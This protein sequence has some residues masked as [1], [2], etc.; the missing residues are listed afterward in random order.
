VF[1]SVPLRRRIVAL[2]TAVALSAVALTGCS[3]ASPQA[4]SALNVIEPAG[5]GSLDP[6]LING[7]LAWYVD[8]AYSPLIQTA[9]GGALT[10]GLATHWKYVGAGNTEFELTLRDGVTFSDGTKLTAKGV[11]AHLDY[12]K[13]A[14][15]P[16]SGILATMTSVTTTGN[17]VDI[18]FS[19][20]NPDLPAYFASTGL[21]TIIS[22]DGLAHPKNLGTETAGAGPYM[23]DSSATVADDHYVY[24]PNPHYWDKANVH[25]KKVT[26]KVIPN[27]TSVLNAL[28]SGQAD[29]AP[30]DF[31]TATAA[32][33]A[34]LTVNFVP[35]VFSGLNL[36]DR[37]GTLVPALGDVRVRQAINYAIDRDAI[38]KALYGKYGTATTQTT[39]DVGFQKD[40]DNY[41]AYDPKKAKALLTAAGYPNGFTLA[42]VSTPY[43]S[44]DT[45]VQAIASQLAKVGI[46]IQAVSITDPN[47]WV[48]KMSSRAYPAAWIGFGSQ[49]IAVEGTGLFGPNGL[50]N[51]F[52]STDPQLTSDLAKLAV[53]DQ[54]DKKALSEAIETRIVK[55]AWYAPVL[56]APLGYYATDAIDPG[57]VKAITGKAPYIPIIDVK[58]AKK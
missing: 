36:L 47:E 16:Q 50:F 1:T 15:G 14:G 52:H 13:G 57:V 33:A 23:L 9:P 45:L 25:W 49:P 4:K 44:A 12:V 58:P 32:S 3:S 39:Q 34:K 10:P 28:K 21:G 41:Y 24:V 31:T 22:T 5:P 30:G 11:K 2:A 46:T 8:L 6:V 56:W 38:V 42:V 7:A 53:A 51:A 37:E 54:A 26:I 35:N 55:L 48:A 17:V 20:P 43:A 19:E 40:L 18:T 29:L 27:T